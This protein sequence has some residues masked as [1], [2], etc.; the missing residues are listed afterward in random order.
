LNVDDLVSKGFAYDTI[1]GRAV[2]ID[3]KK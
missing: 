3:K 2:V 1:K